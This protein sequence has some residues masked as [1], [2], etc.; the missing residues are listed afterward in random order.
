[1]AQRVNNPTSTHKDA[2]SMPGLAQW[3]K[4][5]ALPHMWLRS[6][7]AVAVA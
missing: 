4:D 3:I 2:D 1:M 5:L 7:M 6:G